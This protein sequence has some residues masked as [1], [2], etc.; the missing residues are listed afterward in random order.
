MQIMHD[1][2]P[3]EIK[4]IFPD[5]A[6]AGAAALPAPNMC[7]SMFHGHALAQLRTP[8]RR[9]LAFAQLLQQGFIGMNADAAAS[10]AG[11]AALPQR[12]ARTGGGWKLPRLPGCK[13]HNPAPRTPQFVALPIELEGSFGKIRPL[14]PGPRLAENGQ[15]L[16]PLLHQLTGQI[17]PVNMQFSQRA[18]LRCHIRFDG[19]GD[20]GLGRIGGGGPPPP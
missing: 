17:G 6:V 2:T 3:T 9:A 11:G 19:V 5:P 16:A 12:T 15:C 8:L 4:D 7:Q 14:T 20:T 10:G 13:G 18:L 1:S